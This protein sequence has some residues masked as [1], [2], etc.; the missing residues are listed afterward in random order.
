MSRRL[1]LLVHCIST[2]LALVF[3][4]FVPLAQKNDGDFAISL[5]DMEKHPN[6]IYIVKLFMS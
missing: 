3:F 1:L 4:F 2:S 5:V 6:K